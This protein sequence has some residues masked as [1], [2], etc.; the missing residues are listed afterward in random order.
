MR[1]D[2]IP[3]NH[4]DLGVMITILRPHYD[5]TIV[6]SKLRLNQAPANTAFPHPTARPPPMLAMAS[7]ACSVPLHSTHRMTMLRS[8]RP[9]SRSF[10]L[11]AARGSQCLNCGIFVRRG[12]SLFTDA[13]QPHA[14]RTAIQAGATTGVNPAPVLHAPSRPRRE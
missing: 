9:L 13:A 7:C 10:R 11:V 4:Y 3:A 12:S 5:I 8:A 1:C 6:V 2:C 14:P